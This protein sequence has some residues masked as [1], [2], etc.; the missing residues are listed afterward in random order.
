MRAR[1]QKIRPEECFGE[2]IIDSPTRNA[3]FIPY[4]A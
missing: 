1:P 3:P 4:F 2:D